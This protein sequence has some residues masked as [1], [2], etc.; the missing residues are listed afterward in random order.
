MRKVLLIILITSLLSTFLCTGVST[1][2]SASFSVQ[3][4]PK[5]LPVDCTTDTTTPGDGT[6]F[7]TFVVIEGFTPD[8]SYS[9]KSRIGPYSQDMTYAVSW[10]NMTL[11]KWAIDNT[12]SSDLIKLNTDSSGNW[13]G[14]VIA[15]AKKTAPQGTLLYRIRLDA[16]PYGGNYTDSFSIGTGS[17][18]MQTQGGWIEGIAYDTYGCPV[19]GYPV[20][21][22]DS[23]G[24]IVGIYL[25]EDNGVTEGY[26]PTPGYYKVSAPAGGPYSVE[27]CDPVTLG[28]LGKIISGVFV[29]AGQITAGI[30]INEPVY[31]K[32][33]INIIGEGS[34]GVTPNLISGI[35]LEGTEVTLTA[36]PSVGSHFVFW[37]GDISMGDETDNPLKIII[38]SDRTVTAIFEINKYTITASAG[39]GGSITPSGLITVPYD[40][41][42]S[43]DIVPS[44]GYHIKDVL[45]DGESVG[46]TT[47][48]TFMNITSNHTIEATFEIDS[49]TIV[50]SSDSGGSIDP[51][52][53]IS[54][55]YGSFQIF[56]FTPIIG[57]HIQ[58]VLV[59][60]ESIGAPT[61]YTFTN[62]T[63]NHTIEVQ[64][65]INVY[66]VNFNSQGGSAVAPYTSVTHG[67]AIPAPIS[68]TRAG[69]TFAGWY[70]EAI[71]ENAWD[72][73]MDIVTSDIT[74]YAKWTIT[75][76]TLKVNKVGNGTVNP[77]GGNYNF[78]TVVTLTAIP[79]T[80]YHFVRWSGNVPSGHESDNPL[81][82]TMD[83][84]KIITA[85]FAINS[86]AITALAGTGGTITPSGSVEVPYGGSR[87][88][89]IASN[90]GYH[91]V[92]VKVDGVS[93]GPIT[94][95]TFTNVTSNHT[96]SAAFAINTYT[97]TTSASNGG[98]ITPS[99]TVV[100]AY[101]GSQTFTAKANH[102]YFIYKV[103]V[104]NSPV[105]ITNPFELSYTFTSV[106][107]NHTISA[108]F[109]KMPD[110]TPP[111]L[112][113]PSIDGVDLNIPG[114]ILYTNSSVFTFL[115]E[116]HDD[117][118]IVRMVIKVNGV[119]QIDKNN[120]DPTIYLTEGENIVE[121]TVYDAYGNYATK[122]F[123]VY[124]DTKPP[125]V[126]LTVPEYTS[127]SPLPISG[128]IC[129]ES[130]G[131]KKLLINNIEYLVGPSGTFEAS[132]PLEPG[133]NTLT[134]KAT[135][136]LSN[137]T[138]KIY[139]VTY[140]LSKSKTTII[141]LKI[142]S[143]YIV[144]DGISNKIDAQG[145]KPIIKNGRTLL[146]IR[147]LIESLGGTIEWD[148]K[149]KKVSIYLNGHSIIL[150]IG[151]TTAL[152]DGSKVT[153][154]V[155]TEIINS[156]TYLPLRF[157]SENLGASVNWDPTTRT[158][159]IY[160]C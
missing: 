17:L 121:V 150:W 35:Y 34:V 51:Q 152:V 50:A 58:D 107:S 63:T 128:F 15:K 109:M 61:F 44:T 136:K 144:I 97:I 79:D 129:D 40:T 148:A 88:F 153:L 110:T 124:S 119:V 133:V 68:P 45:V 116:A 33:N 12:S 99:G 106:T 81:T 113:L 31:Y 72:F 62:V 39:T 47:S 74:L 138:T 49:Y 114:S 117:S 82:I 77:A 22:K 112:T 127:T 111:T 30:N 100:V 103:L 37:T 126:N 78:G 96:I 132:I 83:S 125:V 135:D 147:T 16:E 41:E 8:K 98:T 156:R 131:I 158:I 66:T 142:D 54:V 155:A 32:L 104:D 38:D 76:Y 159:T 65:E 1:L 93:Q 59:D 87:E 29:T 2:K 108:E 36:T 52:G 11:N 7:A 130:S 118:G 143:P 19:S 85:E 115:V 67:S 57:Y 71:C 10:K 91:I 123:K 13:K 120:L 23:V 105:K 21:V 141:T 27:I 42:Q 9:I 101:G 43:F 5:F 46:P 139:S 4:C 92:D 145:S 18:N 20:I 149:E 154:D 75:T 48:F 64:F 6:P 24:T 95:Y 73:D 28:T 60:G 26:S 90:T 134:V 89:T 137:T 94:S 14:W 157:I 122:S 84:D 102:G 140:Y 70:K 69:Y 86:Y 151:K 146:P 55:E 53:E 160:Y 80:G 56:T 3:L 25:T